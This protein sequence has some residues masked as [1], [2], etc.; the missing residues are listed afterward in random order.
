MLYKSIS[1]LWIYLHLL[2]RGGGYL[3]R[4]AGAA[5][6]ILYEFIQNEM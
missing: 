6:V 5:V 3:G 2:L 1:T 4:A